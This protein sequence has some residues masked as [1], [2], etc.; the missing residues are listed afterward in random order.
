MINK[1]LR[2]RHSTINTPSF[3]KHN[4]A[5]A[6]SVICPDKFVL[7]MLLIY[8]TLSLGASSTL[9]IPTPI[10]SQSPTQQF[11]DSCLG[12]NFYQER[13]SNILLK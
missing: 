7:D 12:R 1:A 13:F 9:Y 4:F 6:L 11:L 5:L 10:S 8:F 3:S 2:L